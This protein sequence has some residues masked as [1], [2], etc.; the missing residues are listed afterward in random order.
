VARKE[1]VNIVCLASGRGSNIQALLDA[2]A[3][4]ELAARIV[5]VIS[6]NAAAGALTRA[7]DAG[8]SALH[9]SEKQFDSYEEFVVRLLAILNDANAD[10]IVLAGY[11]R[12]VP[13][14]VVARYRGRIINVHPALLPNHGGEGMYGMH[15]HKAVLAAGDTMSGATVHFVDEEYDR[16]ATIGQELVP[17]VDGDTPET[18]AARVLDAEHLL[19]VHAVKRMIE[20]C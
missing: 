10:L 17:V 13:G 2:V 15:V 7:R 5:L 8:V 3:R 1:P 11:L 9:L 6:N 16:G 14:T 19:I 4:G 18:L 20:E 12:K